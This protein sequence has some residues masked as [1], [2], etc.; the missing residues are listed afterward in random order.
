M[1]SEAEHTSRNYIVLG[2]DW[3]DL[4]YENVPGPESP[5]LSR[6]ARMTVGALV[7]LTQE[8]MVD[9]VIFTGGLRSR[10]GTSEAVAMESYFNHLLGDSAEQTATRIGL[11]ALEDASWD[12]KSS[13]EET[14][15]IV[16]AQQLAGPFALLGT[17]AHLPR[18]ERI[19]RQVG[20]D[21]EPVTAEEW[22]A[23][24][25]STAKAYVDKYHHSIHHAM[26][27]GK[28]VVAN[29]LGPFAKNVAKII[30]PNRK[31]EN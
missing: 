21:V 12:T 16:E 14:K 3:Q 29:L 18:A 23:K 9:N 24:R 26:W 5:I 15:A 20:L 7:K 19:F 8:D 31:V 1:N 28:E 17:K 11:L 27:V 13:A 10:N 22:F 30:R 4:G 6:E 2:R 25:S